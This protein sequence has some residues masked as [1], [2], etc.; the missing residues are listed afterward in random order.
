VRVPERLAAKRT[1]PI[2]IS[3]GLVHVAVSEIRLPDGQRAAPAPA[4][5]RRNTFGGVDWLVEAVTPGVARVQLRVE[6]KGGAYKAAAYP[7]LREYLAWV[8]DATSRVLALEP[9]P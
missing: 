4:L 5:Q 1:Q 8:Q 2:L 6:L 7:E 9:A 3:H